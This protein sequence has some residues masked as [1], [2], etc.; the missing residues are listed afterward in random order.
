MHIE[1]NNCAQS[2]VGN[3]DYTNMK[4]WYNYQSGNSPQETK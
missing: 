3:Y 2:K 1:E 4:M